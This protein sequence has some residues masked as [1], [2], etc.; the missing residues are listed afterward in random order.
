M[1][2]DFVVAISR[3]NNHGIFDPV[4]YAPDCVGAIEEV[5][6]YVVETLVAVNGTA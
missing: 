5:C 1:W 6:S 3:P 4:G 2:I